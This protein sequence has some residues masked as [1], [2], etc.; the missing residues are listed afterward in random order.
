MTGLV[1]T[2]VLA[3]HALVAALPFVVPTLVITLVVAVMAVR[4]RRRGDADEDRETQHP[5]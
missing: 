1:G 5:G 4:D 3:H 2:L